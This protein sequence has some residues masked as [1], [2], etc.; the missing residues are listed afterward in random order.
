M[1]QKEN[2]GR[3]ERGEKDGKNDGGRGTEKDRK[4]S[5]GGSDRG[6]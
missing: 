1:I 3:I 4:D 5:R 6:A 2:E